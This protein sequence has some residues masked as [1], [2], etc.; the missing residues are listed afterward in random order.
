MGICLMMGVVAKLSGWN[1]GVVVVSVDLIGLENLAEKLV[2]ITNDSEDLLG[3]FGQ[4]KNELICDEQL[5]AL[6]QSQELMQIMM[7]VLKNLQI[8]TDSMNS[9]QQIVKKLPDEYGEIEEKG[10]RTM[11]QMTVRANVVNKRLQ[12]KLAKISVR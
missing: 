7:N 10:R 5:P 3:R 1:R 11:E 2:A 4:L 12:R 9:I 6:P 8:T